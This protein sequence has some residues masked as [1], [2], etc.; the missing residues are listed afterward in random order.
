MKKIL[1]LFI[2]LIFSSLCVG[3]YALNHKAENYE[4]DNNE[5]RNVEGVN[6]EFELLPTMDSESN[7]KNQVWVGTFQLVWNDLIDELIKHPVEFTSGQ[8]VMADKLNKKA[9]SV[10]DLSESAYYKN[11]GLV[12]PELKTVMENGIK[13][14]FNET[15]D[16]LD[17]FDWTPEEGKYILYAM[18]KKDFEFVEKFNKLSEDI[19]HGSEGK[20]EYF[21]IENDAEYKQRRSVNVL[22]YNNRNDFAVQLKSKQ[23]DLIYLYRTNDDKTL[24]NYYLD[25]KRKEK[26]FNGWKYLED[27]DK[28]KAPLLDF[29]T[30]REFDEL[31]G[32]QIKNSDFMI[33]KA[34]ETLQFKMDE[35]GVKL[36]SEAAIGICKS[37]LPTIKPI[38]RY[39]YFND[40]YVI[41]ISEEGKSPYFGMKITDA[42]KLQNKD[43]EKD[44]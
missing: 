41:F 23:G 29:K 27:E 31:C 20:V 13:A 36:K 39:F 17:A 11:W 33:S 30:K 37:C 40:K 44:E 7:A 4:T 35:A 14:K 43:A 12:S 42:E 2:L 34:I 3:V 28:F 21:G 24:D 25:M 18:L 1:L 19:F 10:N 22:F 32:K 16:I 9:F 26:D 38:P 15:S 5:I 6:A 8:P